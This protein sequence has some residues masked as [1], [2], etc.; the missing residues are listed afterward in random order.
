LVEIT[1]RSI[2][3]PFVCPACIELE[4][5]LGIKLESESTECAPVDD[6]TTALIQDLQSQLDS[7]NA[8]VATD[9]ALIQ[10]LQET[11]ET[12]DTVIDELEAEVR[13]LNAAGVWAT[14][15]LEETEEWEECWI[16]ACNRLCGTVAGLRSE[17]AY[18]K[19]AHENACRSLVAYS[20]SD[21]RQ[22]QKIIDLQKELAQKAYE[23]D[24]LKGEYDFQR[25]KIAA[26]RAQLQTPWYRKFWGWCLGD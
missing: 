15:E 7:A 20:S 17:L 1:A 12:S 21:N 24:H 9:S 11:L 2:S 19:A 6:A 23:I 26:L 25:G 3:F 4:T 5:A 22:V 8:L 14:E 10:D 16:K 13:V 18:E